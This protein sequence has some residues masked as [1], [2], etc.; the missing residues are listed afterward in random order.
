MPLSINQN[1]VL[2]HPISHPVPPYTVW[3]AWLQEGVLNVNILNIFF[4]NNN[5]SMISHIEWK[6]HCRKALFLDFLAPSSSPTEK[7][8]ASAQPSRVDV[9][10]GRAGE[11]GSPGCLRDR[12]RMGS[13]GCLRS[14]TVCGSAVEEDGMMCVWRILAGLGRGQESALRIGVC[15]EKGSKR[16]TFLKPSL[17]VSLLTVLKI[18][19]I[20][21]LS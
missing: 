12:R 2:S 7:P 3:Q 18:K 13:G 11:S 17:S 19:M 15:G 8:S 10:C 21:A 20:T 5:W 1:L 16:G 6:Y 4:T 9:C 14:R